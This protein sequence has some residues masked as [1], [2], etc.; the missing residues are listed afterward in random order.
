MVREQFLLF[1]C[2]TASEKEQVFGL[3]KQVFSKTSGNDIELVDFSNIER[4]SIVSSN[5]FDEKMDQ[6]PFSLYL[7]KKK[8]T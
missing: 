8:K 2:E 3:F 5:E 7:K 1:K 4:I 6:Y